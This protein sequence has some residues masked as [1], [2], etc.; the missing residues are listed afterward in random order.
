MITRGQVWEG[1]WEEIAQHAD[2]LAGK[3]LRVEVLE[4]GHE[5]AIEGGETLAEALS[6]LIGVIDSSHRLG[7]VSHLSEDEHS[8]SEDLEQK[9]RE[10][11]L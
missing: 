5:A 3:R 9:R 7:G 6:G 1:T 11:F 2:R 4:N 10:G 8:F